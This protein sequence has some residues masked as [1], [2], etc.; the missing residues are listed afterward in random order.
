MDSL[1]DVY[2]S[3][4]DVNGDG[5]VDIIDATVLQKYLAEFE[6]PYPIGQTITI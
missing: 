5:T 3:A 1:M 4:A 6:L 2:V